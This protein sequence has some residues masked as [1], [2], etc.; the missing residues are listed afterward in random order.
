MAA[1]IWAMGLVFYEIL[2]G[3]FPFTGVNHNDL[4]NNIKSKPV[5]TNFPD[6][7]S[8]DLKALVLRMLD[9]NYDTRIT[10]DEV[11][12]ELKKI[13]KGREFFREPRILGKRQR[14]PE[15]VEERP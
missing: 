15:L 4:V 12:D 13:R 5:D 10:C 9:N 11:R 1:D 3:R 6:F 14:E 7:V 8:E 2:T